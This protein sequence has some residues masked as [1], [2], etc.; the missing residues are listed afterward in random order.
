MAAAGKRRDG[1]WP[2]QLLF[3]VGNEY[4]G[5]VG[6][7]KELIHIDPLDLRELLA[8]QPDKLLGRIVE[9]NR[10]GRYHNSLDAIG[11]VAALLELKERPQKEEKV[12]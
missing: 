11:L 8:T 3:G 6:T 5:A 10:R 9:L 2:G 1:K 12:K 7:K 4:L